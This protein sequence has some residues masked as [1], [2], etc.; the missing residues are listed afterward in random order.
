MIT[1][2]N[3]TARRCSAAAGSRR[4][5]RRA[6]N[7]DASSRRSDQSPE[8]RSQE[9]AGGAAAGTPISIITSMNSLNGKQFTCHVLMNQMY[10]SLFLKQTAHISIN[11]YLC[12]LKQMLLLFHLS[13]TWDGTANMIDSISQSRGGNMLRLIRLHWCSCNLCGIVAASFMRSA[14]IQSRLQDVR[15]LNFTFCCLPGQ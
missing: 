9:T 10:R 5:R 11:F 2:C 8:N 12:F 7:A 3:S 1:A 6:G 14:L 13:C 15:I 4:P